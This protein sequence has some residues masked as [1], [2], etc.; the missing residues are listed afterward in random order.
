MRTG[1]IKSYPV[2]KHRRVTYFFDPS[3]FTFGV[4]WQARYFSKPR[5]VGIEVGPLS[6]RLEQR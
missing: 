3:N 4:W 6:M 1:F 2:G 5:V